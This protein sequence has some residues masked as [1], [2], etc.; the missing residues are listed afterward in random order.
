MQGMENDL[1]DDRHDNPSGLPE[2][3]I[4]H[5]HEGHHVHIPKSAAP[6]PDHHHEEGHE[7]DDQ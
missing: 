2:E 5:E 1:H 7:D 3:G 6:V 4:V